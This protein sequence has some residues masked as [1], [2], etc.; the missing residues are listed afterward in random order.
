MWTLNEILHKACDA[1][2]VSGY[3][4]TT[5]NAVLSLLENE[6]IDYNVDSIGNVI[7]Q[8]DGD[9]EQTLMI[10]AHYDEIGFSVKYIDDNG[11]I[12]LSPVGGVDVSILHGQRVVINHSGT[13]VYGVVGS[14]PIHMKSC[15]YNNSNNKSLDISDLWVDIGVSEKI[16]N[17]K[18]MVSIGDPVSYAP[19]YTLLNNGLVS[20]K[21]LDN[22]SGFS[23]LLSLCLRLK[24]KEIKRYKHIYFVASAQEE[25]GLRGAY[26]AGY[27]INPDICIAIDTT[28]ATD[29]PSANNKKYGDIKLNDGAVIPIGANFNFSLQEEL[30][31]IAKNH[32]VGYQL[33]AIPSHSG[34]D[35][36]AIQ[37][38]KGGC[39]SGLISIPCRY[40][41]CPTEIVSLNDIKSVVDILSIFIE[42]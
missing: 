14:Q 9:G 19:N 25:L 38:E 35:I 3:E 29:Y 24:E 15:R 2:V 30:R 21:S 34:T 13:C 10:V 6:G 28:H 11:Y 18:R 5:H 1:I 22:R 4:K 41:H 7:F 27:N 33:D 12:Y 32:H 36:A 23:A 8:I 31:E 20:S 37:L 16:T 39:Q 17:V 40:M 26:V 42:Q